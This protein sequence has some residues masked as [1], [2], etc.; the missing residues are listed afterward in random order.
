[1][2]RDRKSGNVQAVLFNVHA[3]HSYQIN[4]LFGEILFV[5]AVEEEHDVAFASRDLK[6]GVEITTERRNSVLKPS[7]HFYSFYIILMSCSLFVIVLL[8]R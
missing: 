7:S 5:N 8:F 1:M 2:K 3:C 6:C 4:L